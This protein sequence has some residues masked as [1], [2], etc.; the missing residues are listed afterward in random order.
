VNCLCSG[1]PINQLLT[2]QPTIHKT[3]ELAFASFLESSNRRA[4]GNY[5]GFTLRAKCESYVG[6]VSQLGED[7]ESNPPPAPAQVQGWRNNEA[8][9][10][11]VGFAVE[12]GCFELPLVSFRN[13]AGLTVAGE[14]ISNFL[15]VENGVGVVA[16]KWETTPTQCKVKSDRQPERERKRWY[17]QQK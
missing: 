17:T 10:N 16:G 4:Y 15:S 14:F 5:G 13:D 3:N 7:G 1:L 9:G 8:I 12:E 11:A 6:Y 2:D